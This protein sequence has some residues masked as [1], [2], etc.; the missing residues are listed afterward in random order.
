M[1]I[2]DEG[3]VIVELVSLKV[4]VIYRVLILLFFILIFFCIFDRIRLDGVDNCNILVIRSKEVGED[5]VVMF[6][7]FYDDD[8]VSCEIFFNFFKDFNSFIKVRGIVMMDS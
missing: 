3:C 5:F 1:R 8:R 4:K 7:G 6:C 2:L